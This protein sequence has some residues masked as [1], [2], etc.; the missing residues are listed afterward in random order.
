MIITASSG[1]AVGVVLTQAEVVIL[2]VS[3][4]ISTSALTTAH[5]RQTGRVQL[6]TG[7]CTPRH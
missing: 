4:N 2:A 1:P 7:N 5:S 3:K 6:T